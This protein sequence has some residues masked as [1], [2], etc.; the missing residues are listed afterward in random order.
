M[1]ADT[2]WLRPPLPPSP[3][4]SEETDMRDRYENYVQ[5]MIDLGLPYDSFDTWLNR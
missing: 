5:A 2:P 1:R 4:R 3:S